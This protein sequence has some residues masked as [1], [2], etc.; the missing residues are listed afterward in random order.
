MKS[1]LENWLGGREAVFLGTNHK[2]QTLPFQGW[3]RF[4]EAYAPEFVS[5][6]IRTHPTN[7]ELCLDPFGGSGTTALT[8]QMLGISSVSIEVNPF[9]A[10]LISAKTTNYKDV[11]RLRG[12]VSVLLSRC[13]SPDGD[14]EDWFTSTLPPTFLEPGLNGKW[15]FN[16]G[17]ALFVQQAVKAICEDHDS[18]TRRFLT[19]GMA[20][21]LV[22]LSNVSVNGKGRRYRNNWQLRKTTWASALENLSQQFE[23]ML[24]DVEDY[25]IDFSENATVVNE[26]IRTRLGNLPKFDVAVFSPPYPNSFDYTDVYNMELWIFKYINSRLEN[27]HLRSST[28][29]S[30]VQLRREFKAAPKGSP[31]LKRI[32]RDLNESRSALWNP[33]LCEMVAGYFAELNDL[34]IALFHTKKPGG[35]IWIMVGSSRYGG[36]EI[37]TGNVLVEL[38]ELIGFTV[39][40]HE[41]S[42]MMRSSPQQGGMPKLAEQVLVF[43]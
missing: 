20:S 23:I 40:R 27:K 12:A 30:H 17:I 33:H 6:A 21:Q 31:A 18:E 32:M 2:S 39:M 25:S 4:K 13:A 1:R 11:Q 19:I 10:D 28:L 16:H 35:R 34:L 15:L 8:C 43:G 38:A 42:R 9:L 29:S 14:L 41:D 37:D 36:I 24:R 26:D 7:V 3:Y 22:P 5:E